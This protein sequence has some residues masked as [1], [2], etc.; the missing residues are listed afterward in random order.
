VNNLWTS[1]KNTKGKGKI[2]QRKN[3]NGRVKKAWGS[4]L[5]Y[6]EA[7]THSPFAP[8]YFGVNQLTIGVFWSNYFS[9]DPMATLL[10]QIC[11]ASTQL[12]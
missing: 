3:E 5:S 11:F 12:L 2:E 6:L 8:G 4:P 10:A 7:I 9:V 1:L